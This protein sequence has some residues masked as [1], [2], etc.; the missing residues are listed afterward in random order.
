MSSIN[1][2]PQEILLQI[3]EYIIPFYEENG[4]VNLHRAWQMVLSDLTSEF[5]CLNIPAD[6]NG[7]LDYVDMLAQPL[8]GVD[9]EESTTSDS[10]QSATVDQLNGLDV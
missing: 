2:L 4:E 8:L 3:M 9:P 5:P 7:I 6:V 10:E 1:A